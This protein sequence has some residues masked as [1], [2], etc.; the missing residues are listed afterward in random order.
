MCTFYAATNCHFE[1]SIFPQETHALVALVVGDAVNG[2]KTLSDPEI[3]ECCL[4]KLR[5]MFPDE[6]SA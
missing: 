4:K 6:V 5:N 1:L 3:V 2:V